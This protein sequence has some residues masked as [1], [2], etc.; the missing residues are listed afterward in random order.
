M[1]ISFYAMDKGD[2][3]IGVDFSSS[4]QFNY[5]NLQFMLL[6]WVLSIYATPWKEAGE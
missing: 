1:K 2:S 3:A 5:V 6:F 4:K